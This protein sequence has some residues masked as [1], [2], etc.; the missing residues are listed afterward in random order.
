MS[1]HSLIASRIFNVPIASTFAV[2]SDKSKETCRKNGEYFMYELLRYS[3]MPE[4]IL[5]LREGAGLEREKEALDKF[6]NVDG[7]FPP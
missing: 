4:L 1:P 6:A 3:G 5:E 2:Y 7:S